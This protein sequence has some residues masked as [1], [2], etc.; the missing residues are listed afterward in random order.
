MLERL[1]AF[2]D[3]DAL[4]YVNAICVARRWWLHLV[5]IFAH[6]HFWSDYLCDASNLCHRTGYHLQR[7]SNTQKD[8][9]SVEHLVR[10]VSEVTSI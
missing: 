7:T 6:V 9:S 8:T 1:L 4:P 10:D 5:R 3:G 2:E